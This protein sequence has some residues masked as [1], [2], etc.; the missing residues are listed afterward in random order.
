MD[1]SN[2]EADAEDGAP[3]PG[4]RRALPWT[5]LRI[6]TARIRKRK[7]DGSVF[8]VCD[9]RLA[10]SRRVT[11][12]LTL[13]DGGASFAVERGVTLH[14]RDHRGGKRTGERRRDTRRWWRRRRKGSPRS[15]QSKSWA[16][17]VEQSGSFTP[18]LV[19]DAVRPVS[20]ADD[21]GC[22]M[23]DPS[24][25]EIFQLLGFDDEDVFDARLRTWVPPPKPG[26]PSV[27][28]LITPPGYTAAKTFVMRDGKIELVDY[29]AG[30]EFEVAEISVNSAWDL[31]RA[32]HAT[33]HSEVESFA[34][35]GAISAAGRAALAK[36]GVIYRRSG[37]KWPEA[38]RHLMDA[39]SHVF[40]ADVDHWPLPAGIVPTDLAAQ[41]GHVAARFA[42]IEPSFEDAALIAQA[43]NSAG[44]SKASSA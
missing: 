33:A 10:G 3:S 32:L 1:Q 18:R 8:V 22:A 38:E 23:I 28:L 9:G 42:K 15:G 16:S 29:N 12:F 6:D 39:P 20:A 11:F 17:L 34:V 35:R 41:A 24:L 4:A 44:Q 5:E 26:A 21:R 31:F 36:D 2:F 19:I 25:N 37:D 30:W 40:V 14:A 13:A 43:S 7:D 27:T